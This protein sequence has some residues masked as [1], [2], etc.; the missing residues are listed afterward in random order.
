MGDILSVK[1]LPPSVKRGDIYYADLGNSEQ[2]VGSEQSGRRPV[3]IIQNDKGNKNSPTTIVAVLTTKFKKYMPTHVFIPYSDELP[4]NSMACLE[5]IRTID[6]S[7]LQ[8]YCGNIGEAIMQKIDQAIFISLGTDSSSSL[9]PG[10]SYTEFQEVKTMDM[11]KKETVFDG[12]ENNWILFAEQ[13]LAFFSEIEQY[14]INLEL[15]KNILDDEV[16]NILEY[17]AS[18]NYN[19]TQGYK[20]YRILREHRKQHKHICQELEQLEVLTEN[21]NC[22]QMKQFYQKAIAKMQTSELENMKNTV[23]QQLLEAEVG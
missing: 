8:E 17:I 13:Q 20:V 19:V 23:I 5:Q 10:L 9:E 6:K 21:L 14:M 16:E 7:R 22:E 18:T 15:T 12:K 11:M 2:V 4:R 3:L 1:P